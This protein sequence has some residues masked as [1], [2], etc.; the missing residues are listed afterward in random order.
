MA[1]GDNFR[2]VRPYDDNTFFSFS[3]GNKDNWHLQ[4]T[5]SDG[6]IHDL[7]DKDYLS[8]IN[9]VA[10]VYGRDKTYC[11]FN[12]IYNLVSKNARD[13]NGTP[14]STDDDFDLIKIEASKFSPDNIMINKLFDCFYLTMISEWH[15]TTK[16][17]RPSRLKHSVKRLGVYQVLFEQMD[18]QEAANFSRGKSSKELSQL[19][20][21]YGINNY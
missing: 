12:K 9:K 1:W 8:R 20:E 19:M 21:K 3:F 6:T 14:T 11:S 10:M 2:I 7:K 17:G 4:Y 18:P 5:K 16:S 15:Y 13:H